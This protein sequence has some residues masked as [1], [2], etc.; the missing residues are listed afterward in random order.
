MTVDSAGFALADG[1]L[2]AS[3]RD[4]GRFGQMLLE[5]GGGIVPAAWI[6]ATRAGNHAQFGA[7]YR[8]VLPQGAYHN[9]F[10]IEDGTHRNI[11]ARGVF[12]QLIY[13]DW[14]HEMVV[15]KLS[16]WPDFVNPGWTRATL[17][18]I[19]QIGQALG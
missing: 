6:G 10:W 7:S 15:V 5:N 17:D 16:S 14:A 12:G 9:Q 13:V 2:N 11:M 8:A 4:Y 3:L 18:A 19:R 1:G